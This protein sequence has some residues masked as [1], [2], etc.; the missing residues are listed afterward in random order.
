MIMKFVNNIVIGLCLPVLFSCMD[1]IELD[2][3]SYEPM[4]VVDGEIN[5]KDDVQSLRLSITQPYFQSSQKRIIEQAVVN[6]YEDNILIGTYTYTQEGEYLLDYK[7][8]IGSEY[9][10]EITLPE[11]QEHNQFSGKVII[12]KVETLNPVSEISD[13]RHEYK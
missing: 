1:T 6:L 12:S 11:I 3:K 7:G 5:N 8:K 9:I 10:L 2:V 4:V 13:L